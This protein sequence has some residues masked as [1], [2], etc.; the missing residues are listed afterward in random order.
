MDIELLEK[1]IENGK[2]SNLCDIDIDNINK[3]KNDIL[4][5]LRLNGKIVSNYNKQLK[6]YQYIDDA[7]MF[8][9]GAKIRWIDILDLNNIS[10]R[11]GGFLCSVNNDI[12]DNDILCKVRLFNHKIITIKMSQCLIFQLFNNQEL[13]ILKAFKLLSKK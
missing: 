2:N 1:A 5:Q 9:L 6:N 10:L 7:N 3:K 4:Q 11:S 12:I 13:V 8:K